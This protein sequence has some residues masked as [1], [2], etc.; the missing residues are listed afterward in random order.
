MEVR[1]D[2]SVSSLHLPFQSENFSFCFFYEKMNSLPVGSKIWEIISTSESCRE[3]I[4][5]LRMQEH[6]AP[7]LRKIERATSD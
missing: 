2:F 1:K 7:Y 4:A 3:F 6:G 5:E